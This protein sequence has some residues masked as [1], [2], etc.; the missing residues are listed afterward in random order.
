MVPL[1]LSPGSPVPGTKVTTHVIHA[2]LAALEPHVKIEDDKE[3]MVA[4]MPDCGK[5]LKLYRIVLHLK[6]KK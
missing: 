5:L 6:R 2:P 1:S 3:L 4:L